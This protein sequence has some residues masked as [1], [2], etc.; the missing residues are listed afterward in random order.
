MSNNTMS[1]YA[2]DTCGLYPPIN[3][4]ISWIVSPESQVQY[5]LRINGGLMIDDMPCE[6]IQGALEYGYSYLVCRRYCQL[7]AYATTRS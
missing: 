3:V 6:D 5:C 7:S 4:S 1:F 2:V